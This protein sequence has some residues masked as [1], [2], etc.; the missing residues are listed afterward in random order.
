M[1]YIISGKEFK[2]KLLLQ[3]C[4]RGVNGK[5]GGC[6]VFFFALDV[7][8]AILETDEQLD[9]GVGESID[10]A[11]GVLVDWALAIFFFMTRARRSDDL[12]SGMNHK[13]GVLPC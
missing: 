8:F 4:L 7:D 5:F 1:C 13:D 2:R 9:V 11:R 3:F 6:F 10:C 12:L